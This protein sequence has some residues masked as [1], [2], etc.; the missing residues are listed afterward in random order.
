MSALVVG[1]YE[2]LRLYLLSGRV[3]VVN[4]ALTQADALFKAAITLLAEVPGELE[5]DGQRKSTE[6][7]LVPYLNEFL[8]TLLVRVC[9]CV[10]E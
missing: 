8:S 7:F 9:D 5:M 3:A 2:R 4:L 1:I 10:W 6:P